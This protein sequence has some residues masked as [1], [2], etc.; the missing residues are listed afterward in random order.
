[1]R[2]RT[3]R[4]FLYQTPKPDV[5]NGDDNLAHP[6]LCNTKNPRY[7]YSWYESLQPNSINNDR[8]DGSGEANETITW[9][10]DCGCIREPQSVDWIRCPRCGDHQEPEYR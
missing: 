8:F 10:C 4:L 5:R 3:N 2:T 7:N 1:M 9:K 6:S